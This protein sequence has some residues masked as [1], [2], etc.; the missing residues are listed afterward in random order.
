MRPRKT[1]YPVRPRAV[2]TAKLVGTAEI[3]SLFQ[4]PTS[5]AQGWIERHE[6]NGFPPAVAETRAT[7]L[8]VDSD[9]VT[10]WAAKTG[11][12]RAGTMP[13]AAALA[14]RLYTWVPA[15]GPAPA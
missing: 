1:P 3:A 13:V 15:P 8:W 9:V 6:A 10:W 14:G 7:L 4:V 5:T 12:P 2:H 11:R